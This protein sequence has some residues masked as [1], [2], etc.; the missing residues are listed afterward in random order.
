MQSKKLC[1]CG[2]LCK[3]VQI[4]YVYMTSFLQGVSKK[5]HFSISTIFGNPGDTEKPNISLET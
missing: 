3:Y 4:V 2:C 1:E 5:I